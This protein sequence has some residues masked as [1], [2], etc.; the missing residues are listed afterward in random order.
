MP[1]RVK[2]SDTYEAVLYIGSREGYH[3]PS[4]TREDLL[5]A[6]AEFQDV[7]V[8]LAMPVR[9]SD[10]LT[11]MKGKSYRED[12]WE[13]SAILY[14]NF[15]QTVAKIDDFILKLGE[16]LLFKFKQNRI[17]IRHLTS[18]R[19]TTMLEQHNAERT[20]TK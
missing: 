14:P 17:T 6:V 5:A 2:R 11:F 13:I 10:T 8:D 7:A 20:H 1:H 9:V 16:H 19:Q 15:P 12:G 18:E 3:G 4:F